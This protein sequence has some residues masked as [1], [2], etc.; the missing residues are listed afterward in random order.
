MKKFF[1][2]LGMSVSSLASFFYKELKYTW[3][4]AMKAS[5]K[6]AQIITNKTPFD[7]AKIETGEV[8]NVTSYAKAWLKLEKKLVYF[9]EEVGDKTQ[10]RCFRI[11]NINF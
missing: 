1:L 5:W 11:E 2:K 9:T 4:D 8:R 6:I 3:S 7:F 10:I